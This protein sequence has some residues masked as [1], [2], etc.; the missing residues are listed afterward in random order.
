MWTCGEGCDVLAEAIVPPE[1]FVEFVVVG[2]QHIE[3][4]GRDAAVNVDF[5]WVD[6]DAWACR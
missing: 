4:F 3:E 2:V 5:V 6:A 1:I